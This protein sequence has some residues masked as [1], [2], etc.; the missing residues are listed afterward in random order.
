MSRVHPTAPP[1]RQN[2]CFVHHRTRKV[3]LDPIPM[4]KLDPAM[5]IAIG[6]AVGA[7][8]G[9]LAKVILALHGVP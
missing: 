2:P 8:L 9:G 1:P 7:I 5:I 6:T 4:T 3:P